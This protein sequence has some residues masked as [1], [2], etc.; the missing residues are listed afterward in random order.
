MP[1]RLA[2]KPITIILREACETGEHVLK[3]VLGV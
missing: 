3:R 1:N 2:T